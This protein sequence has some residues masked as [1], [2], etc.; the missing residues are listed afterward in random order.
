MKCPKVN[1]SEGWKD[2]QSYEVMVPSGFRRIAYLC[3][4]N[5]F[6]KKKNDISWPQK[7]LQEEDQISV[8]NWIFDDPFHK[9]GP[10]SSIGHLGARDD[11]IIGISNFF[12]GKSLLRSLRPLGLLRLLRSLRPQKF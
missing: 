5:Q 11:Q 2:Q 6:S 3:F 9:K 12:D 10:V 8:K 7:P 4:I 1:G